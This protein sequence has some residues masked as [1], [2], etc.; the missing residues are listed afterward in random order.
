MR[1]WIYEEVVG[2]H[3]LEV[4]R[5]YVKESNIPEMMKLILPRW[6]QDAWVQPQE[7]CAPPRPLQLPHTHLIHDRARAHLEGSVAPIFA[8]RNLSTTVLGPT[9]AVQLF[10]TDLGRTV[11]AGHTAE[12]VRWMR[13]HPDQEIT[14]PACRIVYTKKHPLL[15]SAL[16][17]SRIW[18]VKMTTAWTSN[19]D[20]C[21]S[22]FHIPLPVSME[23]RWLRPRPPVLVLPTAL[24]QVTSSHVKSRLFSSR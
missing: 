16:G 3:W 14:I 21:N 12:H 17:H 19:Q 15:L 11:R 6:Q 24:D 10:D 4:L 5:P 22:K 7:E 18:T 9:D 2:L 23:S 8:L 1:A 13:E 20:V